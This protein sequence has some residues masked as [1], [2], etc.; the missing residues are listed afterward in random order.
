MNKFCKNCGIESDRYADG[1]CKTCTLARSARW[2]AQ[3]RER[4]NANSRAWNKRNSESKRALNATYRLE[5]QTQINQKRKNQRAIDPSLERV[6]AARRR[7]LKRV[8][9]GVLSKD[10]VQQLLTIQNNQCACCGVV[11]I[12]KFHLDHIIPLSLGGQNAD[13]NVQLLLPKCNLQKYNSSPANF[14]SR[15]QKEMLHDK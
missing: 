8:N 1:R 15:R 3:N 7:A 5:K 6:K 13:N 12:G 11:F 9:G 14:L 10:I 4:V 2:A